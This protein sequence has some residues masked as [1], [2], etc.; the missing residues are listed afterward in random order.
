MALPKHSG[1]GAL[2]RK[3]FGYTA[4]NREQLIEELEYIT[5]EMEGTMKVTPTQIVIDVPEP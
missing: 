4:P 2:T 5:I 1:P 3:M